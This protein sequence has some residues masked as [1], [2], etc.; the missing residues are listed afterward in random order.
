MLT[1]PYQGSQFQPSVGRVVFWIYMLSWL[2]SEVPQILK[3]KFRRLVLGKPPC[4]RSWKKRRKECKVCLSK[5]SKIG[6]NY[7]ELTLSKLSTSSNWSL[8]ENVSD[9]DPGRL[10]RQ[11]HLHNHIKS[12]FIQK[13]TNDEAPAINHLGARVTVSSQWPNPSGK[14]FVLAFLK[15]SPAQA[16]RICYVSSHW[17]MHPS[18]R[19]CTHP[20]MPT[21]IHLSIHPSIHACMHASIHP[22]I[23]TNKQI[24]K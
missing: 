8:T 20:S 24:N 22:S 18:M 19:A 13:D 23:H 4:S 7:R 3:P 14:S 16:I 2:S 12:I 1:P 9:T 10:H 17:S 11:V 5:L 6:K 21:S 15:L